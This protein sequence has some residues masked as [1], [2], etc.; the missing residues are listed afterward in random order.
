MRKRERAHRRP[1][2]SQGC[3]SL[4]PQHPAAT[5][6]RHTIQLTVCEPVVSSRWGPLGEQANYLFR[7]ATPGEFCTQNVRNKDT[8]HEVLVVGRPQQPRGYLSRPNFQIAPFIQW[9]VRPR[10]EEWI[11][12][13]CSAY[14]CRNNSLP[15][16]FTVTMDISGTFRT[17]HV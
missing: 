2:P 14:G 11:E 15:R 7:L 4:S 1:L 13:V 12:V 9:G 5:P 10:T 8:V 3:I 17:D 6:F 16:R